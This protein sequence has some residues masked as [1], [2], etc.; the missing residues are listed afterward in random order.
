MNTW[1]GFALSLVG[2]AGFL[3]AGRKVW[4]AWHV[5]IAAQALWL[6]YA[7]VTDQPGFLLGVAVYS[8]VFFRN[9]RAWTREHNHMKEQA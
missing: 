7:I 8:I 3:L 5:N 4:W 9:A 2:V 6:A 1:W